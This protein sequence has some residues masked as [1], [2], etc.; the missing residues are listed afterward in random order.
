MSFRFCSSQSQNVLV[1][2]YYQGNKQLPANQSKRQVKT[3][4]DQNNTLLTTATN[5]NQQLK[6][7]ELKPK[8]TPTSKTDENEEDNDEEDEEEDEDEDEGESEEDSEAS[9]DRFSIKSDLAQVSE[10][11][12]KARRTPLLFI[13]PHLRAKFVFDQ[14]IKVLPQSP[15]DTHQPAT[16]E[17]V[18]ANVSLVFLQL[19]FETMEFYSFR[20]YIQWHLHWSKNDS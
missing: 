2:G 9:S 16:V 13:R 5:S 7:V 18:S 8:P 14:L 1:N 4:T 15:S 17:I 6:S 19:N 10:E 20:V 11:F 3:S 12:S